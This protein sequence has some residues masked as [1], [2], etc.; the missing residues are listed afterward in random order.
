MLRN[1]ETLAER[2]FE[3][4]QDEF[5]KMMERRPTRSLC[6]EKIMEDFCYKVG[7]QIICDDCMDDCMVRTETLE[8]EEE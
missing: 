6:R 5:E 3:E 4:S 1:P 7:D 8:S 2:D